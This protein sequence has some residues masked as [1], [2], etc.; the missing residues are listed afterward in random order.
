MFVSHYMLILH[1]FMFMDI[2]TF[3][4]DQDYCKQINAKVMAI[5]I[6][7]HNIMSTG[8]NYLSLKIYSKLAKIDKT[9]LF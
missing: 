5:I 3:P 4:K 6:Y 8:A 9:N 2:V 1:V 7:Y